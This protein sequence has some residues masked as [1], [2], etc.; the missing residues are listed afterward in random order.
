MKLEGY[1]MAITSSLATGLAKN[2]FTE[3]YA[4]GLVLMR[5]LTQEQSKYTTP[6]SSAKSARKFIEK[7][8][9]FVEQLAIAWRESNSRHDGPALSWLYFEPASARKD[10]VLVTR[11]IAPMVNFG[12]PLVT[13]WANF[14]QHTLER[15]HQRLGEFSWQEIQTDFFIASVLIWLFNEARA[16]IPLQQLFLP[17][18]QGIFA[19]QFENNS[20]Q[21]TT[22]IP[23]ESASLR[24]TSAIQLVNEFLEFALPDIRLFVDVLLGAPSS[25]L[26][27]YSEW[28]VNRLRGDEY[29]WL[30]IPHKTGLDRI[31]Q[32]WT[33]AKAQA[34]EE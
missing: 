22:Y 16:V 1:V 12:K 28:F 4:R 15:G 19:G 5:Q 31:G 32:I 18:K 34:N 26:A 13:R 20:I 29:L 17:S 14:S 2:T 23:Q 9:P 21:I 24:W 33:S 27:K 6:P 8:K 10:I 30:Q 3:L 25:E 11:T 7:Y